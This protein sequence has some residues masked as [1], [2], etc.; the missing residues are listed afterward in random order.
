MFCGK[1]S[2]Q[3]QDNQGKKE[4]GNITSSTKAE[5]QNKHD[6]VLRLQLTL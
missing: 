5:K 2:A 1:L 6:R 3:N 4:E